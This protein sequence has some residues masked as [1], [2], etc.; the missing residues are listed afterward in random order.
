[1]AKG[2]GPGGKRTLL[3]RP[4]SALPAPSHGELLFSA[5]TGKMGDDD[6]IEVHVDPGSEVRLTAPTPARMSGDGMDADWVAHD[7]VAHLA[8]I[9]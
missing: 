3:P 6:C 2:R 7:W 4:I 9:T 5:C 1:M 8:R